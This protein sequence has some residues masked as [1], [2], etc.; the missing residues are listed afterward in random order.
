MANRNYTYLLILDIL[1]SRGKCTAED[2]AKDEDFS[3]KKPAT[4]R[5]YLRELAKLKLINIHAWE[6][7]DTSKSGKKPHN[8]YSL[9]CN[10]PL[11]GEMDECIKC[12]S[13]KIIKRL[14]ASQAASHT[15]AGCP[16]S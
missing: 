6:E 16:S 10:C 9:K 5:L 12:P 8:T 2:I 15:C 7:E 11:P 14:I 4:I 3:D 13:G 1:F